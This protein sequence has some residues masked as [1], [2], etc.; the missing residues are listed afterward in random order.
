MKNFCTLHLALV[1]GRNS[2]GKILR[3]NDNSEQQ[4]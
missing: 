1:Y 3:L 2:Q 4:K